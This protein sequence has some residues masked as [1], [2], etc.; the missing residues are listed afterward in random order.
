MTVSELIAELSKYP[1][2]MEVSYLIHRDMWHKVSYIREV[3]CEHFKGDD[4]H[5]KVKRKFCGIQ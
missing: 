1:Q 2:D 5:K 3:V 4:S